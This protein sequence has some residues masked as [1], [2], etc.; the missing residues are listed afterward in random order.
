MLVDSV[1]QLCQTKW[2]RTLKN[3]ITYACVYLRFCVNVAAMKKVYGS[4][5]GVTAVLTSFKEEELMKEQICLSVSR[6]TGQKQGKKM[7]H[8]PFA[9]GFT[10]K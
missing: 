8:Q 1:D 9:S 3:V 10:A 4:T 6:K 5:S 2:N 7:E